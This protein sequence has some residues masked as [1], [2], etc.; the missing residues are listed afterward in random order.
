MNKPC[1]VI[2]EAGINHN[3]RADTAKEL[4]DVA[5]DG[6]ADAVKFQKRTKTTIESGTDE[7]GDVYLRRHL[8]SCELSMDQHIE[9]KLYCDQKGIM[10]MCS[11]MDVGSINHI[12]PLVEVHKIGSMNV[13]D[14]GYLGS[15]A[16]KGKPIIMSTGMCTEKELETAITLLF[17]D[18]DLFI[19][20]CCSTYPAP[21][22]DINFN[23]MKHLMNTYPAV[24]GYSGH[25][26]GI[27]MSLA[28][29]AIGAKIIERHITL[30]RTM[31]G[32][33]HSSSLE[34]GG[35]STLVRDI[36]NLELS[37]GG[38][39]KYISRGEY[40]NREYLGQP[41][42]DNETKDKGLVPVSNLMWGVPV[43][44]SDQMS[45]LSLGP[46]FLEYRFTDQDIQEQRIT[47]AK[48]DGDLVV[49]G[50][51][52]W[53]DTLLDVSSPDETTRK[54]S[55]EIMKKAINL[56][57]EMKQYYNNSNENITFVLHPG[58]AS[59]APTGEPEDVYYKALK[60]SIEDL[61]TDGIN[62]AV[63]NMPPFPWYFGGQW[64]Q[65][66]FM[67]MDT[68][69]ERLPG[70]SVC[71]DTSHLQLSCKHNS[72]DLKQQMQ[73]IMGQ[74][75]HVHVADASGVSGEGL[76]IGEGEINWDK[77]KPLIPKDMR[78]LLEIWQGH[79]NGGAGFVEALR[80][81]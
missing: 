42:S 47:R 37:M 4:I 22:N 27:A 35:F 49:H 77:I 56:T 17:G 2:A 46:K 71:L 29:V 59:M 51:E 45:M 72:L 9:L 1:F 58:A 53:N 13:P 40:M 60:H 43:R 80:R 69:V 50:P 26:R 8:V 76:Q 81:F 75:I 16:A 48:I 41:I 34:P 64:T 10:Y 5:I 7:Q 66:A 25:E 12:D 62:I 21:F 32:P 6:G 55:V 11:A 63:E 79:R 73:V 36:R 31:D 68:F 67:N 65:H 23:Y 33:D 19:L 30:D 24:V 18:V 52:F 44:H 3:G 61:T 70:L 15:V 39:K 78:V 20:H 38:G 28:A 74:V 54:K 57:L 14:L